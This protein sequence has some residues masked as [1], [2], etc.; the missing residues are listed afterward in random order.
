MMD[1]HKR[2]NAAHVLA[3]LVFGWLVPAAILL[4]YFLHRI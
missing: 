4:I 2:E 1:P 3:A